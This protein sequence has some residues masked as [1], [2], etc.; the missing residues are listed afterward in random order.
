MDKWFHPTFYWAYDYLSM[1]RLRLIHYNERTPR[2]ET[3]LM[4]CIL[5]TAI[6]DWMNI[7][8]T[9][10]YVLGYILPC[11]YG[12]LTYCGLLTPYGVRD[13][14]FGSGNYFSPLRCHSITWTF[15]DL[16]LIGPHGTYFNDILVEIQTFSLKKCIY[17]CWLQKSGHF[18]YGSYVLRLS[19]TI[20]NLPWRMFS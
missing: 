2:R 6:L 17:N 12:V 7:I 8:F 16:L 4:D 1:L 18:V 13:G 9:R 20:Y 5:V 3:P 15:A 14:K 10:Q 19:N 11:G